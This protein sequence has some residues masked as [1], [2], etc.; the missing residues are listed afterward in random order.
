MAAKS[1]K[2]KSCDYAQE[3]KKLKSSGA[4]RLY[5][6]CGSEDF[7]RDN[8]LD[9]LKKNLLP[10]GIDDFSYRKFEGPLL[11]KNALSAA[12]DTMPFLSEHT[13]VELRNIDINKLSDA[14]EIS[15]ILK[16]IPDYCTVAFVLSP[17]YEPDGRL[18][19]VKTIKSYGSML[20]FGTP[21]Q[22]MLFRWIDKHFAAYG[23]T[24]SSPVKTRLVSVSGTLMN[25]LLPEISKIAAYAPG[26]E[27]T[28]N[29][30]DAVANKIPESQAFDLI[31]FISDKNYS[32][33]FSLMGE[34]FQN[35]DNEPIAMIA[36][37]GYQFRRIF[38]AKLALSSGKSRAEI[39]EMFD[40]YYDFI[41]DDLERSA[42]KFSFDSLQN[43]ID[44]CAEYEYKMKCTS[45]EDEILFR[46][47]VLKIITG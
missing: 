24:I 36:L 9:A 5:L 22:A 47:L 16:N 41:V 1:K 20:I 12:I 17:D 7:L 18:K 4:A 43:A 8:F 19:I 21:E 11:D 15:E 31:S 42:K 23:K 38:G 33:A 3:I 10:D 14:D 2:E 27:I 6:L 45:S 25:R 30:V 13:F 40:I 28:A 44:L 29:D 39:K 35:K 37:L 32:R 34:L 26:S 46:D